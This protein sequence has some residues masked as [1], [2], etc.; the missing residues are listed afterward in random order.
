MHPSS[1]SF[2]PSFRPTRRRTKV[3]A[4]LLL[5]WIRF[6]GDFATF[7]QVNFL[8]H[9]ARVTRANQP[10]PWSHSQRRTVRFNLMLRREL[11][12]VLRSVRIH[13]HLFLYMSI[14]IYIYISSMAISK[15]R[16][17]GP[18][19]KNSNYIQYGEAIQLLDLETAQSALTG[20]PATTVN[21]APLLFCAMRRWHGKSRCHRHL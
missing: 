13:L 5:S 12:A 15:C 11:F 19:I 8:Q 10:P 9:Q 20:R 1:A 2:A 7:E 18:R 21:P 4:V 3:L 6:T 14:Y 17:K 16:K